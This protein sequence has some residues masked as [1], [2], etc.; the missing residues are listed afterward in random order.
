M[1]RIKSVFSIGLLLF[2]GATVATA[3]V[4]QSGEEP[5]VD[6]ATSAR[7][8]ALPSDGLVATFFHGDVRCPTCR[9]IENY[10]QQAIEENFAGQL[11]SGDLHWHTANYEA[12]ANKHYADDYE[13]FSSTVVLVR[14]VDGKPADWRNLNRVWEF[15][16]DEQAFKGYVVEQAEEML[17]M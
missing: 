5:A 10:A 15:V 13:I 9:N 1:N 12:P 4:K 3:V 14:M 11:T 7:A 17:K 2:V 16:G 8:D 6:N